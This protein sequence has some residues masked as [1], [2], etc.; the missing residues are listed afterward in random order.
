MSVQAYRG[1]MYCSV[2]EC[3]FG[4][5]C[6]DDREADRLAAHVYRTRGSDPRAVADVEIDMAFEELQNGTAAQ[7]PTHP[8]I[9][10]TCGSGIPWVARMG[11]KTWCM[12]CQ[13]APQIARAS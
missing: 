3:A 11:A 12:V 2:S 9:A 1:R 8:R 7:I 10:C 4:P 6:Q 13:P 5:Q